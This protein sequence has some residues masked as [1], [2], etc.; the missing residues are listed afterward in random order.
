MKT[1][2]Y[3]IILLCLVAVF[4]PTQLIA[5]DEESSVIS[6][7]M[8][9]KY[10]KN[11]NSQRT[12]NAR[13]FDATALGEVALPG[14]TVKFYTNMEE[15]ELMAEVVTDSKGVASYL[16]PDDAVLPVDEENNWWFYAEF[17]GL[18]NIEP[19][20]EEVS[21]MDVNLEMTLTE[22]E[23]E[24]RVVHL[25]AYTLIDGEKIPVTDED[26]YVFVPRMFSLLTVGEGYFED[27]EAIVEF[28]GDIPGDVHGKL[29]VVG[30]FEDHWQFSNVEKRIETNWGIPSSHEVAET[31]RAL[32]TQVAP[33]WMIITLSIMLIGVWGHYV[34]AI[35]SLFR[36]RKAGRNIKED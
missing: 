19:T 8:E 1:K 11:T 7:Y 18:E 14:L 23:E 6:P 4:A 24:G 32:W 13:V 17:E 29:T 22:N 21:L 9:L 12:L 31:H 26:I 2:H 3:I 35:V 5:Q 34:F 25:S 10:L 28:P 27:G 15:Q 36:I 20:S 16:I 33:R 30:R